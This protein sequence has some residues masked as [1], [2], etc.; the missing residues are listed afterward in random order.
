M[1]IIDSI[2]MPEENEPRQFRDNNIYSLL[3]DQYNSSQTYNAGDYCIYE[4]QLYK[5]NDTTTGNWDSTKWDGTTIINE[6]DNAVALDDIFDYETSLNTFLENINVTN[7][8]IEEAK[9][10]LAEMGITLE[11]DPTDKQIETYDKQVM[12]YLYKRATEGGGTNSTYNPYPSN[13]QSLYTLFDMLIITYYNDNATIKIF[14]LYDRFNP[15]LA[16]KIAKRTIAKNALED[17]LDIIAIECHI[18][19]SQYETSTNVTFAP[20]YS[21][22]LD[23]IDFIDSTIPQ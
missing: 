7:A 10:D 8:I 4:Y 22:Y 17:A 23:A 1:A 12:N 9:A 2:K 19:E 13:Y 11:D 14:D 20:K 16:D 21:S 6:F 3:A 5:C 15:I 18:P